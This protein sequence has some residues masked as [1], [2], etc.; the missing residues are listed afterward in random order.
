M[1]FLYFGVGAFMATVVTADAVSAAVDPEPEGQPQIAPRLKHFPMQFG[2]DHDG[3]SEPLYAHSLSPP[4]LY[5]HF[6]NEYWDFGGLCFNRNHSSVNCSGST[7]VKV[8]DYIRLTAERK[9]QRGY[10]WSTR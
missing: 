2:W 5:N 1:R 4:F 10:L 6:E 3:Y 7:L 9:S 8:Y